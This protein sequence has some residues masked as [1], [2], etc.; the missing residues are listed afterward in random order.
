MSRPQNV[1]SS[2]AAD[3][4]SL[5]ASKT[6]LQQTD[7]ALQ[8]RLTATFLA[9]QGSTLPSL[10][11]VVADQVPKK[12]EQKPPSSRRLPPGVGRIDDT[13][14]P[15]VQPSA[16]APGDAWPGTASETGVLP[17]GR[18]HPPS[19]GVGVGSVGGGWGADFLSPLHSHSDD[20]TNFLSDSS[21]DGREGRMDKATSEQTDSGESKVSGLINR[22]LSQPDPATATNSNSSSL[23]V[24]ALDLSSIIR[25]RERSDG[26][27]QPP[28]IPVL[29][30]TDDDL[31]LSESDCADQ[32]HECFTSR[33]CETHTAD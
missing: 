1:P 23:A 2:L 11:A 8:Q 7:T 26:S 29:P 5:A 21:D 17:P 24:P 14:S 28:Q 22:T 18:H 16:K 20:L 19:T 30:Q 3:A 33:L 31:T 13:P 9:S 12:A 32:Q 6:F 27:V 10:A 15:E 25:E 4:R